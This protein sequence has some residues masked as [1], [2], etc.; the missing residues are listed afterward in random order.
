MCFAVGL[1]IERAV[2]R[3]SVKRIK[4][5]FSDSLAVTFQIEYRTVQLKPLENTLKKIQAQLY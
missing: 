3:L 2:S 4:S 1:L 5:F